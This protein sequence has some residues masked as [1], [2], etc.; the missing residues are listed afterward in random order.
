[1]GATFAP[2]DPSSDLVE[3]INRIVFRDSGATGYGQRIVWTEYDGI[4]IDPQGGG[5]LSTGNPTLK[6]RQSTNGS[7]SRS[8][9]PPTRPT[10]SRSRTRAS[11]SARPSP[12][13]GPSSAARSA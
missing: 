6:I 5:T 11:P 13:R 4:E 7:A 1:M 9:T 8:G 2:V 3:A 12:R 10:C